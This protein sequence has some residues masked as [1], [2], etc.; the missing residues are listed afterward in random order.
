RRSVLDVHPAAHARATR[1][2]SRAC[3]ARVG[4][5]SHGNPR[6]NSRAS[7][8]A[9]SGT[10][11]PAGSSP[12]PPP[13]SWGVGCCGAEEDKEEEGCSFLGGLF[14]MHRK[15]AAFGRRFAVSV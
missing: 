1:A 7:D 8:E 5:R 14:P 4:T 12:P 10:P 3:C 13:D 15:S 6:T 11:P 9:P 2:A